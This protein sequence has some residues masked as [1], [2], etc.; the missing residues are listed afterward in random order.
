MKRAISKR[1]KPS[2]SSI[3]VK[4]FSVQFLLTNLAL[5]AVVSAVM[6]VALPSRAIANPSDAETQV[7]QQTTQEID[8]SITRDYEPAV[9]YFPD[10]ET[11]RLVPQPVLVTA[12][13]PVAGAVGQIVEA[14]DGEDV[15][16]TGYDVDVNESS[17]EAEINFDVENPRGG[18]A[19]QS[20]SSSN[21]YA[22]FEAIRE[23]LL[24]EPMYGVDEV[25]FLA[26]DISFDI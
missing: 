7:A 16:I 6:G 17:R 18:R 4:P 21:Q 23:T 15:G 22:L 13:E 2:I 19:F 11:R 26:N 8:T 25:K 12:D 9:V 3:F 20:L 5:S 14:Y 24:T 1:Q 10:P